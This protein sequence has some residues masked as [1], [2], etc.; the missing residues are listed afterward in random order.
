MSIEQLNDEL[1]QMILRGE[2]LEAFER[3]YADDV[4]M[5]E[6]LAEPTVGK[7]ANREREKAF[8]GAIETFHGA[9][10]LSAGAGGDVSFA[11]MSFDATYKDGNRSKLT[12]VA[13]RRWRDGKVVHERFY[14]GAA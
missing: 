14:Y 9:E 4:E 13:V 7:A 11:E 6:N 10:L 1:N 3:F 12:E 8:F 5:Q 2:A